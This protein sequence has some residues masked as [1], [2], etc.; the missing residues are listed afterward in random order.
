MGKRNIRN[1][2]VNKTRTKQKQTYKETTRLE[3][4]IRYS[5][6][7]EPDVNCSALDETL[8][9]YL[10][11]P[12]EKWM[13]VTPPGSS[14]SIGEN[15]C[16]LIETY[17]EIIEISDDDSNAS[18][19]KNKQKQSASQTEQLVNEVSGLIRKNNSIAQ[20]KN[21][22]TQYSISK[23]RESVNTSKTL[24][25]LKKI[26]EKSS[27]TLNRSGLEKLMDPEIT[28]SST[29]SRTA[30]HYNLKLNTSECDSNN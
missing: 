26:V 17:D 10:K 25:K 8:I 16:I 4:S 5:R 28:S 6:K 3:K 9:T 22:S 11:E 14:D 18:V 2:R 23:S 20:S 24:I 15:D 19:N 7:A 13:R 1:G 27:T 21:A 30:M 12:I 29:L